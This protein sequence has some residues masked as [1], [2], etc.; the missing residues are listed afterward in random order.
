MDFKEKYDKT[1]NNKA[2]II[3]SSARGMMHCTNTSDSTANNKSELIILI[4]QS[5]IQT[6]Q[7]LGLKNKN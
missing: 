6:Y 5:S 7:N 3:H 4:S 1:N 2:Q